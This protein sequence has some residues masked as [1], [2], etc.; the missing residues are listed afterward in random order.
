MRMVGARGDEV[1]AVGYGVSNAFSL[2][3]PRH[4]DQG[5][6]YFLCVGNNKAHKNL[7]RSVKAFAMAFAGT[8]YRMIFTGAASDA[9]QAVITRCEVG[10]QISFV[11]AVS[12]KQ[13]ASLYR[14][15]LALVFVSLYEG[16]GLPIIE[17]MACGAPVL[18]ST[19]TAMPEAAGDAA[20]L[21]DPYD[22]DAISDGMRRLA[23]D[24]ALRASLSARGLSRAAIFSW[25]KIGAKV[26]DL[27]TACA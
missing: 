1:I 9:L 17:C 2:D 19:T 4:D 24:A 26:R 8:G 21:V 10:A 18:T 5:R 20:M 25:D 16:F 3:G 6:P 14:G 11:G 27:L 23:D 12:D 15:A 13:L 22:L 7:E